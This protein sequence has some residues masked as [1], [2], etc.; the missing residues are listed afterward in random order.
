MKPSVA[1]GISVYKINLSLGKTSYSLP[2]EIIEEKDRLSVSSA[3]LTLIPRSSSSEGDYWD[4]EI[5]DD[6]II[7]SNHFTKIL[8]FEGEETVF[9]KI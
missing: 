6:N 7:F 4:Y 9:V 2:K 3:M 5:K 1:L 8:D